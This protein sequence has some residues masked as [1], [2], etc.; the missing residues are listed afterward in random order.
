MSHIFSSFEV[1]A[2]IGDIETLKLFTK[3]RM[4]K[5]FELWKSLKNNLGSILARIP[6]FE[7]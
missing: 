2:L 4:A 5:K 6:D 3:A 1:A 7:L